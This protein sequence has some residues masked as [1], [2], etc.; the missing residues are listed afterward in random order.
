MI[1]SGMQCCDLLLTERK[2]YGRSME[3]LPTMLGPC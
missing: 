2:A 1:L 3:A